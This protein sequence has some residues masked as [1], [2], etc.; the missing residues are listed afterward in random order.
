[1]TYQIDGGAPTHLINNSHVAYYGEMDLSVPRAASYAFSVTAARDWRI[2]IGNE[3]GLPSVPQPLADCRATT[4]WHQSSSGIERASYDCGGV[5]L[6][7]KSYAEI[8]TDEK[9]WVVWYRDGRFLTVTSTASSV[10]AGDVPVHFQSI[11]GYNSGAGHL[12]LPVGQVTVMIEYGNWSAAP[13][14]LTIETPSG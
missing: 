13:L 3:P 4:R 10:G 12:T 6:D 14:T 11:R 8:N 7:G 5:R 2:W 9:Y 1:M